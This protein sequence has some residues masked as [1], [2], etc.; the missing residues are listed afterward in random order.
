M[1]DSSL[2]LDLLRDM[3]LNAFPLAPRPQK[4]LF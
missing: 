3:G 2:S 1:A 4:M